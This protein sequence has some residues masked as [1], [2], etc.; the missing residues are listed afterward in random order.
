MSSAPAST[1]PI[2]PVC[3]AVSRD[4]AALAGYCA[5][6]SSPVGVIASRCELVAA[7][8]VRR[9]EP[10]GHVHVKEGRRYLL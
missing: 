3:L 1:C 10:K 8:D 6:V 4:L 2:Q 9:L 7:V 5:A